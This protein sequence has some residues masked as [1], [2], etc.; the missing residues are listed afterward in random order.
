M[1]ATALCDRR[2]A[3][4]FVVALGDGAAVGAGAGAGVATF[5]LRSSVPCSKIENKTLTYPPDGA[6]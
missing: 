6:T 3:P 4:D 1:D 2:R 5:V